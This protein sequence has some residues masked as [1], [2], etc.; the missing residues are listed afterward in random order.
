MNFGARFMYMYDSH[1]CSRMHYTVPVC[2]KFIHSIQTSLPQ[3]DW[4]GTIIYVIASY[5]SFEKTVQIRRV[6][7]GY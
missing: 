7:P 5:T 3:S 4:T 2:G 1:A 6:G